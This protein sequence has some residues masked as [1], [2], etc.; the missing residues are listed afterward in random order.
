MV[1]LAGIYGLLNLVLCIKSNVVDRSFK[2]LPTLDLFVF[3]TLNIILYYITGT[4][5]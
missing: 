3:I 4:K 2:R 1:F 5:V